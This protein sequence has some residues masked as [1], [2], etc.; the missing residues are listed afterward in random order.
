MAASKKP[1]PKAT[2]KAAPKKQ[3]TKK[4]EPKE[5]TPV[6]AV[7]VTITPNPV[8]LGTTSVQVNG[9]G[10]DGHSQV[11]IS[12]RQDESHVVDVSPEGVFA[13]DLPYNGGAVVEVYDGDGQSLA[14][15]I[16][17]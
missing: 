10:F 8:P 13:F 12:S 15:V 17:A 7:S 6:S 1:K 5:E 16:L 3:P 4:V 9:R 2:T 14:T 11:W